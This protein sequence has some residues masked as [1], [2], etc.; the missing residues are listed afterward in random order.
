MSE[1]T[2]HARKLENAVSPETVDSTSTSEASSFR[3]LVEASLQGIIVHR[4]WRILF[5][6]R[7]AA[8]TLGYSTVAELLA[9]TDILRLVPQDEHTRVKRYRDARLKGEP[10]PE[11]YQI[12]LI[13]KN[14]STIWVELLASV[15]EWQGEPALQAAFVDISDNIRAQ[16]ML[17]ESEERYSLAMDGADEGMWDLHIETGSLFISAN[18]WR[19]LGKPALDEMVSTEVWLER[20]H[21][22]DR[23]HMHASLI[24][25]LRGE[26]EY[27]QSEHRIRISDGSYR[28]FHVHG[29]ALRRD[30]GR[31]YRLAGSVHDI[32][33]RKKHEQE[34]SERLHFEALLTRV[35]AEFI[36]LPPAEIDAAIERSLGTIGKFLE[37]DRGW[38]L[39]TDKDRRGLEYTHE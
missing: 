37:V 28:W 23:E 17:R 9:V 19:Y 16:Q 27:F 36:A 20:V 5:A 33:L 30:D 2:A 12:R 29:L 26:D 34:L 8:S 6:N 35:S 25:H 21:P 24:S 32:T 31:A 18:V 39:Q 38:F 1:F 4:D 11:S 10:A 13:H 14:G 15:L 3:S 22:D 7:A